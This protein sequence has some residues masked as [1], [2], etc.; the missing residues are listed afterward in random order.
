MLQKISTEKA[1]AAIGP[2]SQG[3][4]VNGFVLTF[5]QFF[6][7]PENGQ[8]PEGIGDQEDQSCKKM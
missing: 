3:L 2:Y 1:P 6:V 7:K 8:I 5:G 4:E